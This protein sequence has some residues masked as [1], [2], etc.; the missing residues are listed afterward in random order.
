MQFADPSHWGTLRFVEP[1]RR[2]GEPL[3]GLLCVAQLV[4]FSDLLLL[5]LLFDNHI[6]NQPFDILL[7][8][9]IGTLMVKAGSW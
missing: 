5:L 2:L 3:P 8:K 4:V 7:F 9:F 6:V 1:P